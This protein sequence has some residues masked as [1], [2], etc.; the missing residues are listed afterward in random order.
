V[1]YVF[2]KPMTLTRFSADVSSRRPVR[3]AGASTTVYGAVRHRLDDRVSDAGD[4]VS[5]ELIVY[6]PAGTVIEPGD[7][8][9]FDGDTWRV[10]GN[11]FEAYS[12]RSQSVHHLEVRVRGAQR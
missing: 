5:Q 12:Q 8:L 3:S 7:E 4:I 10:V 6:L 9:T 1:S 11:P 2:R